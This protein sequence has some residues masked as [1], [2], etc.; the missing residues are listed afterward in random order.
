[1]ILKDMGMGEIPRSK[2][3]ER[4]PG[5]KPWGIPTLRSLGGEN[6][7]TKEADNEQPVK[8]TGERGI[9]EV[10]QRKCFKEKWPSVMKAAVWTV[11]QMKQDEDSE[12]APG[13]VS[14]T[15]FISNF[16]SSELF[17]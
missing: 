13:L 7:T 17:G 9:L 6:E 15:K 2:F 16:H 1:M 10:K 4:G 12:V 8:G 3:G 11:W 5:M 14:S